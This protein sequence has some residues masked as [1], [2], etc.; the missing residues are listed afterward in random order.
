MAVALVLDLHSR[1]R[2]PATG[3]YPASK[4]DE[5]QRGILHPFRACTDPCLGISEH[6]QEHPWCDP[7]EGG[8]PPA[9]ATGRDTWYISWHPHSYQPCKS[10]CSK[11]FH[12]RHLVYIYNCIYICIYVYVY[13]YIYIY[14]TWYISWHPHSYQPCKRHLVY[15][16]RSF[17]KDTWYIS[18]A[19]I[20][21]SPMK[22]SLQPP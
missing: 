11:V 9:M 2:L 10:V 15:A 6:R 14:D 17:M 22:R 19:H 4:E 13:I 18:C 8:C 1:C 12:E 16:P 7:R 5:G 20:A 3:G 21:T